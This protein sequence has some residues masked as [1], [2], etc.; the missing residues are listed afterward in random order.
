[1]ML[2]IRGAMGMEVMIQ[3]H[4]TSG[5]PILE[6]YV[7]FTNTD[8]GGR[9]STYVSVQEAGTGEQV[10]SP[11]IQLCDGFIALLESSHYDIP[12]SLMGRHSSISALDFDHSGQNVQ[13]LGFDSNL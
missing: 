10:E 8:E 7:E 4:I 12:K 5:S 9:R 2:L 11:T 13:Q 3:M 1:M 6:L